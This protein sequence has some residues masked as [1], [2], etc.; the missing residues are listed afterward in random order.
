M[1]KKFLS[2]G[3]LVFVDSPSYKGVATFHHY[4]TKADQGFNQNQCF[5]K[6]AGGE[7]KAFSLNYV[8]KHSLKKS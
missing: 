6:M 8:R 1:I 5:V 7:V 4:W 3:D 2:K